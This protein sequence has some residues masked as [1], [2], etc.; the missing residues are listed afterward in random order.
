MAGKKIILDP[1]SHIGKSDQLHQ[2]GE[3]DK[4]SKADQKK[5]AKSAGQVKKS[6]LDLN[7]ANVSNALSK[8]KLSMEEEGPQKPSSKWIRTTLPL[9]PDQ[10]E[11]LDN[12]CYWERKQ[13]TDT[14][15]RAVDVFIEQNKKKI[16]PLPED[17]QRTHRG[18]MGF[19]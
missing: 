5:K 6:E 18:K 17:V 19:R 1:Y 10:K 9:R 11:A 16:K 8:N 15:Q 12:Y 13:F 2:S 7:T 14:I 3:S 4:I